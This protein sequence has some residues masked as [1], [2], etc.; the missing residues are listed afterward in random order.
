MPNLFKIIKT[1]NADVRNLASHMEFAMS[2]SRKKAG[3]R[4]PKV[5][6]FCGGKSLDNIKSFKS[7]KSSISLLF[8]IWK[9]EKN[10]TA[11]I[12]EIDYLLG[13]DAG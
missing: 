12:V 3:V 9:M 11:R 2:G 13:L 6:L 8:R 4:K 7:S 1:Q 5:R 10:K